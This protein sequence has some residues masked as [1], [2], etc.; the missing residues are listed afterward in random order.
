MFNFTYFVFLII[1]MVILYFFTKYRHGI[2][3]F[4]QVLDLPKE[5][6]IH[7]TTTPLIGSFPLIFFSL[8]FII[9]FNSINNIKIIFTYSYLFFIMGYVDDR[10]NIN[11]NLKLLISAIIVIMI[12]NFSEIF[13]LKYI[14]IDFLEK[15]FS[16]KKIS[17]F[18]SSEYIDYYNNEI[19][20]HLGNIQGLEIKYFKLE[21]K[22]IK[23]LSFFQKLKKEVLDLNFKINALN[24]MDGINGL[25]SGFASLW[26]LCLSLLSNGETKTFLLLFSI[27]MFVNTYNIIKNKYFLGDSGSLFLGI[28]IGLITIF[29]YNNLLLVNI[30]MPVE[31]IF[32][33][34]MIPGV[35][36][37]RLFLFRLRRG[38]N[39]FSGDLDHLHH[40]MLRY[41][42]L[43]KT[44]GFYF[45][46]FVMTNYLSFFNLIKPIIIIMIYLLI[47]V[48]F[49]FFSKTK[50]KNSS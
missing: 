27:F 29:T 20:T 46:L 25:A 1:S 5:D 45:V 26:T 10:Y 32:I 33:F 19:I 12:L 39:P 28:L 44:L 9:C 42:S 11:A 14:Y 50:L 49:I 8:I 4:F 43:N 3:K 2:G 13:V 18:L 37:F 16:L 31:K 22:N 34:F 23:E 15:S 17:I 47:Y 6:K 35:D 7:I 40:R 36:M 38:K 30:L 48:F 24:L 21:K 41:F